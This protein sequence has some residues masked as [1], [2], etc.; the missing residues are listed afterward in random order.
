MLFSTS[1][2]IV[3]VT[4]VFKTV[5]F[6]ILIIIIDHSISGLKYSPLDLLR[7]YSTFEKLPVLLAFQSDNKHVSGTVVH[8]FY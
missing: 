5:V 7:S 4:R 3:I 6:L 2:V 1:D 8:V